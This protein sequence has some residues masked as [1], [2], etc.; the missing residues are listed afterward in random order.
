M[1]RGAHR[2][3]CLAVLA[4]ATAVLAACSTS[5]GVTGLRQ[6]NATARFLVGANIHSTSATQVFI[7]AF[8]FSSSVTPAELELDTGDLRQRPDFRAMTGTLVDLKGGDQSIP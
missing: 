6:P 4:T 8:Y 7:A 3:C 1:M 2:V 5:D